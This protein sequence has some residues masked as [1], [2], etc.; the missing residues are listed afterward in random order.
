MVI[1]E[2]KIELVG[3]KGAKRLTGL[4][5]SSSSYSPIKPELAQELEVIT[6]LSQPMRL[7]TVKSEEEVEAKARVSLDFWRD[8]YRFLM[9]S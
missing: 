6:P 3:S 2:R 1:I 7:A 8:S 5:D 4:F 9:N